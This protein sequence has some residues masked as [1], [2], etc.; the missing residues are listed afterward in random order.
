MAGHSKWANIKH[1]K[2]G[3]DAVRGKLFTK[4]GREITVAAK[5][6][7]DDMDA[8]ARLRTAVTKAKSQS[9][10]K[11]NI[12]RAIK[13]GVGGDIGDNWS[14]KVYE[15]YGPGGV[16]VVVECL[17][18]N[19]NRTVSEIRHAFTRAGG[20]M[21][22]EGSVSYMFHKNGQIVYNKS[23]VSDF[24][25]LFELALENG[26]DEVDDE[27]AEVYAIT[28][29]ADAF[30]SLKEKLDTLNIEAIMAEIT[31]V[32]ENHTPLEGKKAESLNKMLDI[33]DDCDDV[34]NVYHNGEFPTED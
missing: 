9:M 7:G 24:D 3:Q 32:P 33:L 12:E 2:A 11:D 30:L 29:E 21:G 15:G 10:P 5:I 17:T 1:R 23:D 25:A 8:N 13:K 6:G 14:E 22:T 27:D 20:N 18:D 4:L 19:V 34:Q 28:C 31:R 26:A 16:A